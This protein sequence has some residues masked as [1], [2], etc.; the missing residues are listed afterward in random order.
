MLK[1]RLLSVGLALSFVIFAAA[2]S[3][4]AK[5]HKIMFRAGYLTGQAFWDLEPFEK[6]GY[7]M[8]FVDGILMSPV[9]KASIQDLQWF[10]TCVLTMSNAEIVD[11]LEQYLDE[12]QMQWH[13]PMN[14]L[15][16]TALSENC[17]EMA[18][19]LSELQHVAD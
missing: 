15:A 3:Y 19:P 12:N 11:I 1:L 17:K 8:G 16:Y 13:L 5:N 18:F 7:V 9:F 10:E 14:C 4:S 2:M 6:S